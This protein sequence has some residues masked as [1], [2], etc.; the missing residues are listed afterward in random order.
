MRHAYSSCR[1][2]V[3]RVFPGS[4]AAAAGLEVGDE[5]VGI[6]GV[7][8]QASDYCALAELLPCAPNARFTIT[9]LRDRTLRAM[10][11]Q[12]ALSEAG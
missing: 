3:N 5:I 11:M 2:Q 7:P 8:L 12:E 10:R 1:A 4:A 9:V 6:N